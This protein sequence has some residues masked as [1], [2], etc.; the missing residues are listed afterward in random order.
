LVKATMPL[1]LKI[2]LMM[3]KKRR[4]MSDSSSGQD[5]VRLECQIF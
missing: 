2:V 3:R 5:L 1:S 4:C